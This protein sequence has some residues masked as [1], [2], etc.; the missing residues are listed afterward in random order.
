M[1]GIQTLIDAQR[2]IGCR[3]EII[4]TG[5]DE[6]R[7]K[8]YVKLTGAEEIVFRGFQSGRV[9]E[10]CIEGSRCVVVPSVWYENGPYNVMEAM[11]FGKPL[12]VSNYG[13]LP[14]LVED[15]KNGY[16]YDGT[17]ANTEE[18]LAECIRRM[19]ALTDQEYRVMAQCSQEKA[20]NMFDAKQYVCKLEKYYRAL[21]V[22][23]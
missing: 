14:E 11:S 4:G 13:G 22:Q 6:E 23:R 16:V 1:E 12:I 9:L 8:D 7:L 3:L 10:D 18:M 15:G 21:G 5:P 19:F 20:R 2:K 17:S